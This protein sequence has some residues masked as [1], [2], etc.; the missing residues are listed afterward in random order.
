MQCPG[1]CSPFLRAA[2]GLPL[3]G[4]EDCGAYKLLQ[5]HQRSFTACPQLTETASDLFLKVFHVMGTF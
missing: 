4:T 5:S 1:Q 3:E 2:S